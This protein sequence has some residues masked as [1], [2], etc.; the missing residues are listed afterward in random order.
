MN[1]EA[2]ENDQGFRQAAGKL[3]LVRAGG[4][5]FGIFAEEIS[6]IVA[7]RQPTQLPYAPKAVLGV[8]SIE[9]RMLTVL[10]LAVLPVCEAAL[11]DEPRRAPGHIIALRGDEQLALA[12]EAPGEVIQLAPNEA[13]MNSLTKQETATS[14][15]LGVLQREGEEIRILN[16]KVLFPIAIQGHERRQRR[17]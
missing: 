17:F 15:V 3:Q 8:V 16:L 4:S 2:I 14:P 9:G 13:M 10:D 5:Q 12:I 11:S 7:W 6:A 1:T